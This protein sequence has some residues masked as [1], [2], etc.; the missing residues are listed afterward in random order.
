MKTRISMRRKN[1]FG[2]D[3]IACSQAKV[4]PP[5][6]Q[7]A[8]LWPISRRCR[9]SR[10]SRSRF[11]AVNVASSFRRVSSAALVNDIAPRIAAASATPM[12][13]SATRT[14]SSV[15]P[16]PRDPRATSVLRKGAPSGLIELDCNFGE[17]VGYFQPEARLDP[18]ARDW[19]PQRRSAR[20]EHYLRRLLAL[21]VHQSN[22]LE[23]VIPRP[24]VQQIVA[25]QELALAAG[26]THEAIA[27][28]VCFPDDGLLPQACLVGGQSQELPHAPPLGCELLARIRRDAHADDHEKHPSEHDDHEQLEQRK[29]ARAG[30][31]ERGEPESHRMA[32]A[33]TRRLYGPRTDVRVGPFAARLAI[34]A[35]TEHVDFSLQARTQVLILLAPRILRQR[36]ALEV[37]ALLPVVRD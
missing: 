16:A 24:L 26:F 13:T 5:C 30:E 29:A 2:V 15:K 23:G 6:S 19:N 18:F 9:A 10:S 1:G 34:T 33:A 31:S 21:R 20:P 32:R 14:S 12:M 37:S 4:I 27:V 3:L 8:V 11:S 35:E 25:R 7:S 36:R 28:Q 22:A 17:V